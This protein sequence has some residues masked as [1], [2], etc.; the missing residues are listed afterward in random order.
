MAGYKSVPTDAA[1]AIAGILPLDLALQVSLYS[2]KT[3]K[4][5]TQHGWPSRKNYLRTT[6]YPEVISK[7]TALQ[8]LCSY[9]IAIEARNRSYIETNFTRGTRLQNYIVNILSKRP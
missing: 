3:K 7:N 9:N 6:L 2:K 8:D 4:K 1:G 5:K